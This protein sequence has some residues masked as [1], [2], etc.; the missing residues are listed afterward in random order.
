MASYALMNGTQAGAG[1]NIS[2]STSGG[3][4][5]GSFNGAANISQVEV[6]ITLLK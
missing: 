1:V 6:P 2:G 4:G 5:G 3:G